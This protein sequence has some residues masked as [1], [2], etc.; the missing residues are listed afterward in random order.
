MN[1][2]I[3]CVVACA[4]SPGGP[5]LIRDEQIGVRVTLGIMYP[6]SGFVLSGAAIS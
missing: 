6:L 4:F 1:S 3:I 2:E 5:G